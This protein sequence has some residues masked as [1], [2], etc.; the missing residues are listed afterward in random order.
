MK[1][2]SITIQVR[3]PNRVNI[4]IDGKFRF[5]LDINQ[6]VDFK[7]KS[8]TE[9]DDDGLAFLE[10]E[11]RFG[12]LYG[13]AAEYCLMRPRSI[14]ELRDYLYKKTLS[15]RDKNG[16]LREGYPKDITARVLDRLIEKKLIDD[17]KFATYWIEN[18]N[19]SKGISKRKL[20]AELSAKGVDRSLVEELLNS[21]ERDDDLEIKKIIKKKRSKYDDQKLMA[22][23]ARLGFSYDLIK[24]NLNYVE[25]E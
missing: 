10:G 18:R 19:L 14:K 1:I 8:G 21:S 25:E 16:E 3:D 22:Y 20:S 9:I 2:T 17:R 5:S 4:S 7:L 24:E 23:L 11:S 13:R 15:R 6:V 12:K